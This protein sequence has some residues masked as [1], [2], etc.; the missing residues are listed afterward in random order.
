MWRAALYATLVVYSA[1]ISNASIVNLGITIDPT[2]KTWIVTA[3]ISD[4]QSL[5]LTAFSID[6]SG[7][8]LTILKALPASQS[9]QSPA[10]FSQ[11]RSSGTIS[12]PNLVGIQAAQNT[13]AAADSNDDSALGYGY[14]LISSATGAFVGSVNAR[15]TVIL[16]GGRY[17]GVSGTIQAIVS[18]GAFFSLFPLNYDVMVGAPAGS[19]ASPV[20]ATSVTSAFAPNLGGGGIVTTTAQS[21]SQMFGLSSFVVLPSG[22]TPSDSISIQ[23]SGIAPSTLIPTNAVVTQ[24]SSNS[25]LVSLLTTGDIGAAVPT[26]WSLQTTLGALMPG[27]YDFSAKGISGMGGSNPLGSQTAT[28]VTGFVVVPEPASS[29]LLVT[30]GT[31]LCLRR[32][33]KS[34]KV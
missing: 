34:T 25:L 17:S 21:V 32:R 13:P 12:G 5:G 4:N 16:A 3:S 26:P 30:G 23:L 6:V 8:G 22:A 20:F 24:L 28:E 11:L 27:I 18:P 7:S 31:I 10:V 2:P 19:T 29:L 1:S 14:G 33:T 15:G 9:N